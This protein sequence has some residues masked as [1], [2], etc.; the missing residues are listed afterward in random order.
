MTV[1]IIVILMIVTILALAYAMYEV[2]QASRDQKK[3]IS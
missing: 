3:R 2:W 1:A